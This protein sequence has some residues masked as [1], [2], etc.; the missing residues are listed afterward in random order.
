MASA[1][2]AIA[3]AVAFAVW[4]VHRQRSPRAEDGH[5]RAGRREE[6]WYGHLMGRH[7]PKAYPPVISRE[8]PVRMF[9]VSGGHGTPY[10]D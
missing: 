4:I 5:D 3:A 9:L 6:N 8:A 1:L 2:I 7:P 10:K